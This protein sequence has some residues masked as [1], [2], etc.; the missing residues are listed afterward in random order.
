MSITKPKGKY[1]SQS[2][3]V[4]AL[5]ALTEVDKKDVKAVVGSLKELITNQLKSNTKAFALHGCAKLV[6]KRKKARKAGMG[7]NPFTGEQIKLK[8]KPACNVPRAR[9]LKA[10]K[11]CV[12]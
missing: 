5:A 3:V 9:A 11:T 10:L 7:R 1:M 2:E 4:T 8:A 12:A 6:V